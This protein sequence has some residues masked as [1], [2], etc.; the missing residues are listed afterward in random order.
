MLPPVQRWSGRGP[1]SDQGAPLAPSDLGG[2]IVAVMSFRKIA[3]YGEP[4]VRGHVPTREPAAVARA[5]QDGYDQEA[6]S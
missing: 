5:P 2:A 4:P 3:I 1:V 6:Y